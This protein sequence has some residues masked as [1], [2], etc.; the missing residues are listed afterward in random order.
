MQN[1]KEQRDRQTVEDF[2]PLARALIR[3]TTQKLPPLT[4]QMVALD[5]VA[6]Q[7]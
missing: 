5:K 2:Y 4:R 7:A 1:S 3:A 6:I